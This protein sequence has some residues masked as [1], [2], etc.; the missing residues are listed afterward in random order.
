MCGLCDV[1][2]LADGVTVGWAWVLRSGQQCTGICMA[3]FYSAI[4]L[5]TV[6]PHDVTKMT[7]TVQTEGKLK[8]SLSQMPICMNFFSFKDFYCSLTL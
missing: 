3:H 6:A 1:G 7:D 4:V 8:Y 2:P 5:M